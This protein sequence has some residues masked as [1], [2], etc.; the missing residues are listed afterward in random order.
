MAIEQN[1]LRVEYAP[2]T[3]EGDDELGAYTVRPQ[4]TDT[5]VTTVVI[6]ERDISAGLYASGQ[7]DDEAITIDEIH[8]SHEL[9][10]DPEQREQVA[11]ALAAAAMEILALQQR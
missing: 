5:P 9:A 11:R 7:E 8:S 2:P 4:D 1:T 3:E 10:A 6:G